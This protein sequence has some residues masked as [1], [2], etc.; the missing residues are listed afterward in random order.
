MF[1]YLI[2]ISLFLVICC[3]WPN[4]DIRIVKFLCWQV[5]AMLLLSL[6]F[7]FNSE[8]TVPNI[9]PGLFLLASTINM[10]THGF[11][12]ATLKAMSYVF[13]AVLSFYLLANFISA[14]MLPALKKAIV[15]LALLNCGLAT[16]E[17]M[18]YCPVFNRVIEWQALPPTGFMIYP[19]HLS[20]LC[21]IGI[22]FA[23]EWKKWLAVPLLICFFKTHEVSA[24]VGF[25]MAFV[26]PYMARNKKDAI[27]ISILIASLILALIFVKNPWQPL[28]YH[29]FELR[30]Q[31]WLPIFKYFWA[32]PLDG[33]GIGVYSY[34][35]ND[36]L[37]NLPKNAWLELHNEPL[38]G[39]FEMGA[40][41]VLIV[42]GW[43]RYIAQ[44]CFT[45]N[46]YF[47]CFILLLFTS[48]GHSI[49]HFA[50]ILWLSI[51]IFAMFEIEAYH[52]GKTSKTREPCP[53][54]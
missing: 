31:Y 11:S 45:G 1:N 52:Y 6:S 21:G 4:H 44:K 53:A 54:Y 42:W 22:F 35:V 39:L 15:V 27:L 34:V 47:K 20:V 8:R 3:Y 19:V 28:L 18:G 30:F 29:K 16:L 46:I 48:F 33:W 17:Y 40:K 2:I 14:E 9:W 23:L 41:F 36:L 7:F 51:V 26:I 38:Q 10:I 5:F 13:V 32:R 37:P 12:E 49:F 50:D 24:S 43:T 25:I